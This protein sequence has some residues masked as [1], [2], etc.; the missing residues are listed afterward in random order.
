MQHATK[1]A[2]VQ[3]TTMKAITQNEY[4]AQD[5]LSLDEIERPTVGDDEVL[6]RVRAAS[7]NPLDWHYLT[8]TPYFLR[9]FAGLRRPKRTT[10]G[11][12]LAGEVEAVGKSV[13]RF[14][15]GDEVFGWRNGGAFAEYA[16]VREEHLARIPDGLTVEEAAVIP[17]AAFTALQ[18][19]RDVGQ[20]KRG[21]KVL[22]N[23]ASGGVGTFAVQ[24]AKAFGAE[25]TGVCSTRNV[26]LVKSIGA[27]TVVDYTRE[28]FTQ[29]DE[30]YDLIF[31]I[32]GNRPLTTSRGLLNSKGIYVLVGGPKGR[33]LGPMAML[34]RARVISMFVSQKMVS[35]LSKENQED[36]QVLKGLIEGGDVTPVVSARYP[37][38]EAP[39]ALRQIGAGHTRGKIVIT[40]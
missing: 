11:N 24:I 12:D 26:D 28:D 21:H 10:Q 35:M 23:G 8:G 13:T 34:A 27:D 2:M 29:T 36:L 3:E 30:R 15:P 5:V 39:E 20:L 14:T 1:H 37:L 33:W 18:G 22:I 40:I 31:D 16:A 17:V 6:V 7:P 9:L 4:G 38:N 32:A 19:L 25:V